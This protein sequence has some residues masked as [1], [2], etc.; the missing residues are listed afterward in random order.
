MRAR[1]DSTVKRTRTHRKTTSYDRVPGS[2]ENV[3]TAQ[4][5]EQIRMRSQQGMYTLSGMEHMLRASVLRLHD[6]QA[7][8]SFG[9]LYR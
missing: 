5:D 6:G 7:L 9:D 4:L 2:L 8:F 3:P 1:R